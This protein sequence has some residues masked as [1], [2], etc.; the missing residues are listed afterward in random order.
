MGEPKWTLEDGTWR[1]EWSVAPQ[2]CR[3][4]YVLG[5]EFVCAQIVREQ[6]SGR[7]GQRWYR[8]LEVS[9]R[10]RE[11]ELGSWKGGES[12]WSQLEKWYIAAICRSLGRRFA[13][14][15]LGGGDPMPF[16]EKTTGR[17]RPFVYEPYSESAKSHWP[18]VKKWLN[19]GGTALG[20]NN[21]S[22]ATAV[23]MFVGLIVGYE[24]LFR[25]DEDV[26]D[27]DTLT[28]RRRGLRLVQDRGSLG[29][30][31]LVPEGRLCDAML[32]VFKGLQPVD[33]AWH[34][35][36]DDVRHSSSQNPETLAPVAASPPPPATSKQV[37]CHAQLRQF[38]NLVLE[39]VPGTGKTFAYR[40]WIRAF[41]AGER[42]RTQNRVFRA[43]D[44][45][46][47]T[48]HAA[49]AYE[50]FIEGLRPG[51]REPAQGDG[52]RRS[53]LGRKDP[54]GKFVASPKPVWSVWFHDE[55]AS[56]SP[57]PNGQAPR[58]RDAWT[59]HDG[60]FLRACAAAQ[61][62]PDAAHF[63]LLDELNRANVPAVLGDLLTLLEPSK[64]AKW[65]KVD[66]RWEVEHA[67]TLPAS[68]RLFFVPENLYVIA[69]MNTVDRS[70][71]ALDQALRRRFAFVRVEPMSA[72][73]LSEPLK[74]ELEEREAGGA[75][76]TEFEPVVD[77]WD[78]LNGALRR[79]LGANAVLGHSYFF[80]AVAA[81]QAG[82]EVND[83]LRNMLRYAL[84]PQLIETLRVFGAAA[85]WLGTQGGDKETV[86]RRSKVN[87][88]LK[89]AGEPVSVTYSEGII[90]SYTVDASKST[91][92]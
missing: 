58:S 57:N 28:E 6:F 16:Q 91:G 67:V 8:A 33:P 55:P 34:V 7:D 46:Q 18:E 25:E 70:V 90:D 2:D 72:E 22:A 36:L 48:F 20:Q 86:E 79:A 52:H 12:S 1:P 92:Q 42:F 50:D 76:F 61:A 59:V 44:Y 37:S 29:G 56:P 54:F 32:R 82:V 80:D 68:R 51:E 35:P 43:V 30:A 53:E 73:E 45:G 85:E 81:V 63:V 75:G 71:A 60:F 21:R 26:E 83:A 14:T 31:S 5:T 17:P 89:S 38:A 84:I 65:N 49:T 47:F 9:L 24:P 62:N 19:S 4:S 41:E 39:G 87:A 15:A 64:R 66:K 40:D 88:L 74:Y 3:Q 11:V 69:T 78:T 27:G 10:G 23:A 13:F 77:A